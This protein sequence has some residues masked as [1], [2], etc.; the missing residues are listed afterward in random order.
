MDPRTADPIWHA[1]LAREEA[2]EA[3]AS[4]GDLSQ[5]L[6]RERERAVNLCAT[7]AALVVETRIILASFSPQ[8]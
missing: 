1:H 5:R 7:A 4:C 3:R 2:R 6:G 8:G